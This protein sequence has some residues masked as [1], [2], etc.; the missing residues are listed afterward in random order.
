MHTD[1]N[2]DFHPAGAA[3]RM[4]RYIASMYH[5]P[6]R[7]ERSGSPWGFSCGCGAALLRS[8]VC[9]NFQVPNL[10]PDL[11]PTQL[12]FNRLQLQLTSSDCTLTGLGSYPPI[13]SLFHAAAVHT[14][15]C[16]H[17]LSPVFLRV[18][19]PPAGNRQILSLHYVFHHRS[20]VS[21]HGDRACQFLSVDQHVKM[22]LYHCSSI[23]AM[24]GS[25]STLVFGA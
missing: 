4:Y 8:G 25:V 1:S 18:P 19:L 16:L 10:Q 11:I 24:N 7:H 15:S 14:V 23:L 21:L 2:L 9:P 22:M 20:R 17:L 5:A 13:P 3:A 12:D 6:P